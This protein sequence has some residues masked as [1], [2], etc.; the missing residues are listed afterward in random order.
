ML[1]IHVG[2]LL[3]CLTANFTIYEESPF[4]CANI[5]IIPYAYQL[6]GVE[7]GDSSGNS[8]ERGSSLSLGRRPWTERSESRYEERLLRIK[9]KRYKHRCKKLYNFAKNTKL[10]KA[11][12]PLCDW[13]RPCPRKEGKD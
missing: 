13:L 9:A 8:R 4:S 1:F 10:Y 2:Y 7:I 5:Q 3:Q 12:S 11:H 6:I